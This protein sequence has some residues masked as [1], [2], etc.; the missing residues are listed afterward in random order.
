MTLKTGTDLLTALAAAAPGRPQDWALATVVDSSPL[1]VQL[2][3]EDDDSIISAP[4]LDDYYPT[5]G[6]RV[7]VLRLNGTWL[8]VGSIGA[9]SG[10]NVVGAAGQP[11]FQNTW[12]NFGGA[13][14][15]AAFR[16]DSNGYV[17]LKGTVKHGSTATTGYTVVFTLPAGYRP[18]ENSTFIVKSGV[19]ATSVGFTYCQVSSTGQISIYTTAANQDNTLDGVTF[20]AEQ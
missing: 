7:L 12:V 20:L 18:L 6:A 14:S 9:V 17:H 2:D 1:T 3:G 5:A 13:N 15:T 19:A 4:R 8:V 11:A 10:W 16:A